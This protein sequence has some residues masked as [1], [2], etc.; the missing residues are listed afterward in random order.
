MS[1]KLEQWL[2]LAFFGLSV[3]FVGAVSLG[4]YTELQLATVQRVQNQLLSI[5]MLKKRLIEQH[6]RESS[7]KL[8]APP[9]PTAIPP[10]LMADLEDIVTERT[11][12]GTTGESYLVDEQG[13]MMTE[14]R[15]FPDQVPGRITVDTDGV[16]FAQA[17]RVG[18]SRYLD[19][20]GVPIIGAYQAVGAPRLSWVILTEIDAA[21]A[22]QPVVIL[23]NRFFALSL[24]LLLVSGGVSVGLGKQ[25]SRPIRALQHDIITLSQGELP[26]RQFASSRVKEIKNISGSLNELIQSLSRTAY[27]AQRIGEGD[28]QAA[29]TPLGARD[30]LGQALLK[31]RDQLLQF[32]EQKEQSERATR[33]RLVD[34][35]EA[36]RERMARDIHDGVGPLLTTAKLKL[37]LLPESR[38]QQEI[39][40]LLGE[41]IHELR[42]ISLNLMPAVLQDFGPG[43]ALNQLAE[44]VRH[45]TNLE[46]RYV[47]DLSDESHLPKEV[48]IT[49]YRI[50]QEA[51]NN[52]LK[53][54]NATTIVMS[55]TEFD[56]QV[57]LY[58][59]D[60]GRGLQAHAPETSQGRGLKNIQERIRI[61]EGNVRIYDEQ[62]TVIE[63][64]IPLT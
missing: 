39:Q 5:N 34:T 63:A 29:Y 56:D 7:T 17:G 52:T 28:F 45:S 19:Y 38:L 14:S 8:S 27:F 51:V 42:R 46:F 3:V 30:E 50:A 22:L 20:R 16:R 58:Y 47:N 53:H 25:L 61:L 4:F 6:L 32:N 12:M 54:A 13:N 15:F 62:G 43:E 10:A 55:L 31:M 26:P 24:L 11:G 2:A 33:R 18:V 37:S 60:N 44:Q 1:L 40:Q 48:G 49:L 21:E 41:V 64:E 36:E 9:S 57:V 23:R 35:Q 59:K